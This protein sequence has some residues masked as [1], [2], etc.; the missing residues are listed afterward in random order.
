M[1][2]AINRPVTLV[3]GFFLAIFF[4]ACS[5]GHKEGDG[6]NHGS[7]EQQEQG[8][9]G[10]DHQEEEEP[11]TASLSEQQI[12]TAGVLLA[13]P[14]QKNLTATI[15]V[16]GLLRVPNKNKAEITS[17]YGGVIKTLKIE[18]GD[19]V[20]KGQVIATIENPLF[21]Q[22]Q[23]EYL[24]IHSRIT[25]AEQEMQRQQELNEGNA[26]AKRNLQSASAELTALRTRKASL[27]QQI[28]LMGIDPSSVTDADLKNTL[29]VTSPI[30]GTVGNVLAKVGSYVD[31]ATPVAEIIDNSLLHLD[32]Q[33][34]ERDLPKI[35]VG[36]IINFT[37]T[38]NPTRL[39]RAKV[40]NIGSSFQS[41][42]KTIAV[43]SSIEGDKKGLI[44]GM[45]ITAQVSV[46]DVSMLAV[47]NEA[48]V[49][50]EGK[51]FVFVLKSESTDRDHHDEEGH[52]HAEGDDHDH[53]GHSHDT[54]KSAAPTQQENKPG[55]KNVKF[56]RVEVAKGVTNLGYTAITPVK[57]IPLESKI[58]VKGA[59]FVNATLDSS[60][61]HA[62]AH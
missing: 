17:L 5:T 48:I 22:L 33:V 27:Q 40:F 44:D 60:A 32:L 15:K 42:S 52:D 19:Y 13:N 56:E 20:R 47:P 55:G 21:I 1:K 2:F 36:Q 11:N 10:H 12:R 25:L 45:S 4:T 26:G 54:Q 16:N 46:E 37:V 24:T 9:D 43:H 61:E 35:S 30:S 51:Y 14:E 34:F 7:V 18:L 49:E 59:F 39:Y 50:A 3:S 41:E 28:R 58:V 29:A 6:H 23:E 57:D 62:H 8:A 38:N 31:V 53:E